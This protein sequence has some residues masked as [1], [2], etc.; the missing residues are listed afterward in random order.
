[1]AATTTA[2]A[3]PDENEPTKSASKPKAKAEVAA[4]PEKL[5]VIKPPN[6]CTIELT[7]KGNAP[8][9]QAAFAAKAIA[10]MKAKHEAGQQAKKL[11]KKEARDFNADY[12]A[13][14]HVSTEGWVGIPASS[15]RN[16]MISAC[17]IVGFKM[18]HAK[19]GV[20]VHQDGFDK[21]NGMPLVKIIGEPTMHEMHARNQTG[22]CD[23][24][25]RPMW[26]EWSAK[27]RIRF[28]ADMFTAQDVANLLRRVG[29]QVGIGEG[30]PDS[31]ESAGVGW[32]TFD[33]V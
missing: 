12:E 11:V 24:R 15:F 27:V 31:R 16:A 20:F 7:I 30:R 23:I 2:A 13:A 29:V 25:V 28:D 8:Y 1:M 9:V 10:M 22:V 14:K 3:A 5:M 33:V 4:K 19:L 32:G 17:K 18:T 6:F 26:R 21:V